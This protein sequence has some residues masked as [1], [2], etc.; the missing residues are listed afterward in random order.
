MCATSGAEPWQ[1]PGQPHWLQHCRQGLAETRKWGALP[2]QRACSFKRRAAAGNAA[3]LQPTPVQR[4]GW[5]R[6]SSIKRMPHRLW[7]VPSAIS[8]IFSNPPFRNLSAMHRYP[9]A[10]AL[11]EEAT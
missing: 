6:Y 11:S 9:P 8:S 1:H 5:P 4:L 2:V 10:T 3:D 7:S